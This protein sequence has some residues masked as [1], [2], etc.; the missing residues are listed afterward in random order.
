[1]VWFL[2]GLLCVAIDQL[3]KVFVANNFMTGQ[4]I[5]V[6]NNVFHFTYQLNDGAAFSILGG[7]TVFL[8]IVSVV[9]ILGILAYIFIK[10]PSNNLELL[11]LTLIIA[12]AVGNLI[13][14]VFR[15]AVIDFLDFT[16]INFP[17]FN[18]ADCFVVIG[19][20]LFFF[21]VLKYVDNK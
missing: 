17:V 4:S 1:M 11:S 8:S 6:I 5:P 9:I 18:I 2:T 7:K 21:Y 19:G 16:L 14:R 20:V 15:G 12:G 13:D 3:S 10:K